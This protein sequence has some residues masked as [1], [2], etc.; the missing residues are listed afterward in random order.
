MDFAEKKT[1]IDA[2][3]GALLRRFYGYDSFRP[4]QLE[5]IRELCAGNDCLVLMP[6]GGGKSLCYQIPALLLPGMAIVVSPLI[7]LMN[8]QVQALVANG[9][10][11]AAL[12]SNQSDAQNAE[13]LTQVRNGRVKLLYVSP[14]RLLLDI[15]RWPQN[16]R[17]S[18]FAIDE[19]HCISQW[20]HDFRPE[21]AKLARIKEVFPKTPVIALTATADKL[22]RADIAERLALKH[23]AVFISSFDRPN[24]SLTVKLNPGKQLK[25]RRICEVIDR[26]ADDSGIIYCLSRKN[27]EQLA[28]ELRLK[29]YSVAA[30]HAGM[31]PAERDKAQQQFIRGE[32]QV[33][34]ATIAFGMGIDKSNIRY[35]IHNNLPKNIEGYYQE[36]GRAGRDGLPAEALMFYSFAD[37]ATLRSFIEEDNRMKINLEKLERMK[38]YAEA[39]VCRRRILLSYFS[40]TCATDC[41]NCDVCLDPPTRFDAT[42]LAQK[43]LS[44][45]ARVE[46]KVGISMLIDILRGSAKADLTRRG[47]HMIKTYGA[48]RDLSN[49]EWNAY[50]SQMIQLGVIEIAYND[51]NR[52]KITAQGHEILHGLQTLTLAKQYFTDAPKK[53]IA[54]KTPAKSKSPNR[55]L[56][57]QLKRLRSDIAKIDGVPPYIICSDKTIQDI[58]TKLPTSKEEFAQIHGIGEVKTQ[59]LW[60]HFTRLVRLWTQSHPTLISK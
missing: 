42:I 48:G 46:E 30:Y 20:G 26:Y 29:G 23:P 7:A 57:S 4:R 58:A 13:V 18:L 19:A 10:P 6:T 50:I 2:Q 51:S 9:I 1:H 15:E 55:E 36:I 49:R 40:E 60:Q 44:A 16:M 21:Y 5:I 14:E 56:I 47:Y 8:D 11:A 43:A 3:A 39:S 35:V 31:S 41:G 25:I 28:A 33:I 53:P 17:I 32:V 45:I 59:R 52:L 22:T 38:D 12:H 27:V 54:T 34:C 24:I 37:I